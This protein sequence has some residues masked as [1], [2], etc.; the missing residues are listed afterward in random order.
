MKQSCNKRTIVQNTRSTPASVAIQ[1]QNQARGQTSNWRICK[2]IQQIP[3][4]EG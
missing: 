1:G 4:Q 2:N 3:T